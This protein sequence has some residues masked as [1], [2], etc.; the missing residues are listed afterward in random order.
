MALSVI[1]KTGILIFTGSIFA[2][3]VTMKHTSM[4]VQ[5]KLLPRLSYLTYCAFTC[6]LLS[7]TKASSIH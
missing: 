5:E 7:N 2:K 1:E 4:T 3:M 6:K